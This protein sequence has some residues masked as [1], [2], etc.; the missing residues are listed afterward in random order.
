MENKLKH[1]VQSIGIPDAMERRIM[2]R[3]CTQGKQRRMNLRRAAALAL[4]AVLMVMAS[5]PA[6]AANVPAVYHK[7]YQIAPGVAQYFKPVQMA[8]EDNGIRMEVL[9]ANIEGDTAD[10]LITVQDL[11]GDRLD[12]SVDLF[13]SYSINRPFSCSAGCYQSDY[14]E[15]TRTAT[16]VIHLTQLDGQKIDGDKLT[17][18]VGRMLTGKKETSG[19]IGGI[20]LSMIDDQPQMQTVKL[21]GWGGGDAFCEAMEASQGTGVAAIQSEEILAQP[22]EGVAIT[23]MGVVDGKVHV[24][25]RYARIHETDNHGFVY[26]L[27]EETGE[28]LNPIGS[29]SFFGEDGWRGDGWDEDIFDCTP[30]ELADYVLYGEFVTCDTLIEGEW[31]VTFPLTDGMIG[32]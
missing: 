17:F 14:D 2:N 20:D 25:S 16:F 31:E 11:T 32:E 1:A 10:I 30:E 7:L 5:V 21:R 29:F 28:T 18:S 9:G 4:A 19:V 6:L 8:C 24:Q 15:E 27:N 22:T 3:L 13:D 12:A 23:A 26:F